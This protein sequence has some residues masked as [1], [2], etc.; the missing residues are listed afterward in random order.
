MKDLL[1]LIDAIHLP[2]LRPEY[3]PHPDAGVTHCNGFVNEVCQNMGYKGFEGL[4]ANEMIE[5]MR[6]DGAWSE[7]PMER[8]QDMANA[9]S[10]IVAGLAEEPHGHV[11]VICPG[12]EK[13]SSRWSLCPSVA[14]V[15]KDVFIGKG[16][17]WAFSVL[18]RLWAWRPSL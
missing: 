11:C 12:R 7:I 6:R 13:M 2:L 3:Q 1:S 15:G 4:L 5:L 16:L 17:S 18:P 8:A 10:L 14:N 9:G